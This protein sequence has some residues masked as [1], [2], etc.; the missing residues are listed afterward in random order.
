MTF[1]LVMIPFSVLMAM[2]KLRIMFINVKQSIINS[3]LLIFLIGFKS[4][5]IL[6]NSFNMKSYT[7]GTMKKVKMYIKLT[8]KSRVIFNLW[9]GKIKYQGWVSGFLSVN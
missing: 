8:K 7:K 3:K 2:K 1:N 5:E 4:N 6:W 9:S